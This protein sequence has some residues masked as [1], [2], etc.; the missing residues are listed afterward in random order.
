MKSSPFFFPFLLS[1]A[2]AKAEM[3][4]PNVV[5]DLLMFA[6]SFSRWPVAPVE[7]ARSEPAKS[8]KLW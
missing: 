5:S 3:T 1:D 2:D 6:P 8:T 7:F 4:F